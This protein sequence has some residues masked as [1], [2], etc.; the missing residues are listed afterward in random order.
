MYGTALV[1]RRQPVH[2]HRW[3]END[4][5]FECKVFDLLMQQL[6]IGFSPGTSRVSNDQHT[7][8]FLPSLSQQSSGLEESW[9]IFD[10]RQAADTKN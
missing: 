7:K 5:P 4:N 6:H 2:W 9:M 1:P 10:R 3:L 8:R